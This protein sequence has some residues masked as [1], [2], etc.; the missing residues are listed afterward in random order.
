MHAVV[1]MKW[2]LNDLVRTC[3]IVTQII[4]KHVFTF[5]HFFPFLED[6]LTMKTLFCAIMCL[7]RSSVNSRA[8]TS[9]VAAHV[10]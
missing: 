3:L 7:E 4:V 10:E 9:C 5:G 6:A 2:C 1:L 8:T